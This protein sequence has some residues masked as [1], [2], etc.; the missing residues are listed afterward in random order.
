MYTKIP[1]VVRRTSNPTAVDLISGVPSRLLR[2]PPHPVACCRPGPS[3]ALL[4]ADQGSIITLL[5][6]ANADYLFMGHTSDVM[7]GF[8]TH[9]GYSTGLNRFKAPGA[10]NR[11]ASA[12]S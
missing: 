6:L 10:A 11:A 2:G 3:D 1:G 12:S 7:L 5:W 4:L 9:V 8:E